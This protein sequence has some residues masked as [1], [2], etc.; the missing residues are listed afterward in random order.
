MSPPQPL[1]RLPLP[2]VVRLSTKSEDM[3]VVTSPC[4]G[5]EELSGGAE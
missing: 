5:E 4:R 1:S 2:S 3:E